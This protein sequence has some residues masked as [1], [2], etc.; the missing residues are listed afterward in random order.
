MHI[1]NLN[2]K[3]TVSITGHRPKKLP[4][5]YE[6]AQPNCLKFKEKIRQIL[7]EM[8]H[9]GF[10]NY[11]T[12]MAEG[13]DMIG[14]EILIDLRN[15]YK[16]KIIGVLP[17]LGQEVKWNPVQ[18]SRY[19]KILSH[20][21]EII[22]LSDHYYDGCMNKRNKFMTKCS[23]VCF[24]CWDGKPSGTGNTVRYAKENHNRIIRIDP[25]K[26]KE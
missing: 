13:F 11:C 19:R 18:Q 14:T 6:E 12:G 2:K 10:T 8:I 9:S 15:E 1:V 5:G 16:I 23:S 20:C 25:N 3:N 4:W 24:A 21:D 26:F 22:V 17:C 7:I